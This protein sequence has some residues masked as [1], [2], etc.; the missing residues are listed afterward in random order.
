MSK[1]DQDQVQNNS[2]ERIQNFSRLITAVSGTLLVLVLILLLINYFV[3]KPTSE[4]DQKVINNSSTDVDTIQIVDGY[5]IVMLEKDEPEYG[6][7]FM[8]PE[9]FEWVEMSTGGS[10]LRRKGSEI[11]NSG[12]LGD[13]ILIKYKTVD[14][15]LS[16]LEIAK[17]EFVESFERCKM[18]A[19]DQCISKNMEYEVLPIDNGEMILI[20]NSYTDS[21]LAIV[22]KSNFYKDSYILIE[23]T[24]DFPELTKVVTGIKFF[25]KQDKNANNVFVKTYT[26][27]NYPEFRVNYPSDWQLL[28]KESKNKYGYNFLELNFIKDDLVLRY[29]FNDLSGSIG[30]R[31]VACTNNQNLFTRVSSGWFRIINEEKLLVYFNNVR[32]EVVL[33]ES[34]VGSVNNNSVSIDQGKIED[35]WVLFPPVNQKYKAC[36]FGNLMFTSAPNA[37]E[38]L[39]TSKNKQALV[40]ITLQGAMNNS[41]SQ[42]LKEADAIVASTQL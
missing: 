28:V 35:T 20:T 41:N 39:F 23:P 21:G 33:T 13:G 22:A 10:L 5:K 29:N 7:T 17:R 4:Q 38:N 18:R 27:K 8:H 15:S 11:P 1:F 36:R 42:T 37:P 25:N 9:D 34:D 6:V 26:N 30:D 3:P 14:S 24:R 32:T 2:S 12:E 40:S 16:L 19:S 31:Y